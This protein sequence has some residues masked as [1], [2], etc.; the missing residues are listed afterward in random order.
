VWAGRGEEGWQGE[1]VGGEGLAEGGEGV[2]GEGWGGGEEGV[3][4]CEEGFVVVREVADYLHGF[5][6]V[7]YV[8][9]C[10]F[11]F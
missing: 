4:G 8:H 10:D 6:N 1:G 9:F 2:G 7:V 3:D 11:L 5:W